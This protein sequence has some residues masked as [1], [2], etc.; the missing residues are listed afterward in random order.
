S[1]EL[2][3]A[4]EAPD[5]LACVTSPSSPALLMR[6]GELALLAPSC[7]DVAC[8]SASWPLTAFWPRAWTVT[9]P[10]EPPADWP[11]DWSVLCLLPATEMAPDRLAC[12]TSP[13]SP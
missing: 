12:L 8:E 6:T 13:S 9:P 1:L 11:A 5:R 10:P 2:P 4:E 3:A 7:L